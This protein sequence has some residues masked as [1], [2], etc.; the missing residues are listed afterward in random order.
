MTIKNYSGSNAPFDG[1]QQNQVNDVTTSIL[2]CR[3]FHP[4][5]R[6]SLSL[7][8]S[9]QE[10]EKQALQK[11]ALA[12]VVA[13]APTLGLV[14]PRQTDFSSGSI[15]F[16][17]TSMVETEPTGCKENMGEARSRA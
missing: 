8:L 17:E 5:S 11:S 13:V 16:Y 14:I 2:F 6:T 12:F 15:D 1:K 4:A 9:G 3:G 7:F 10:T